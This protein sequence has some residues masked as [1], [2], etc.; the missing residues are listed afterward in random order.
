MVQNNAQQE[1]QGGSDPVD[2]R[3]QAMRDAMWKGHGGFE[4]ALVPCFGGLVGWVLDDM[5]SITPILTIVLAT[6]GLGG[7]VANQY[8]R[9]VASMKIATAERLAAQEVKS[10]NSGGS[11][12]SPSQ[13]FGAVEPT[14]VDMSL[15][16]SQRPTFDPEAAL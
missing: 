2:P 12:A 7:A 14:E 11:N 8:Y 6:V 3:G 15:D 16:F 5:L 13:P 1:G 9:Y 10:A 4:I